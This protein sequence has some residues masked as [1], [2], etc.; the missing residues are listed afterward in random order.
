VSR[1]TIG[2]S[3]SSSSDQ[4]CIIRRRLL[5]RFFNIPVVSELPSLFFECSGGQ[6]GASLLSYYQC[7]SRRLVL[8][9]PP[10][11]RREHSIAARSAVGDPCSSGGPSWAPRTHTVGAFPRRPPNSIM[12]TGITTD[13]FYQL[14][15]RHKQKMLKIPSELVR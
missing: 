7:L 13:V 15:D 1:S 9:L 2:F 10:R 5:V 3:S 4:L 6:L 8:H 11:R 12:T 14:H